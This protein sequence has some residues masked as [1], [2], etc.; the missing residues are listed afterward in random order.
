[1]D[2]KYIYFMSMC[3]EQ[4]LFTVICTVRACN[5]GQHANCNHGNYADFVV[6]RKTKKK[7]NRTPVELGSGLFTYL[8]DPV[9]FG[10]EYALWAAS[11]RKSLLAECRIREKKRVIW[12][13]W[14]HFNKM[15]ES[16]WKFVRK[17]HL[18]VLLPC[19]TG[20]QQEFP[21]LLTIFVMLI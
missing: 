13:E 6:C 2:I 16:V 14:P 20:T 3:I 17:K 21:F 8:L 10:Q 15:V 9:V 7:L 11:D 19:A 5:E 1:M 4:W 18:C 12:S